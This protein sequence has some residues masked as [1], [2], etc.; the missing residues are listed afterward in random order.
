MK[1]EDWVY[2]VH[3]NSIPTYGEHWRREIFNYLRVIGDLKYR[4]D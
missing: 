1:H 4:T 2:Q 3:G